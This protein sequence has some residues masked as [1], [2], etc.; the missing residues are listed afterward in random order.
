MQN[1]KQCHLISVI[2]QVIIGGE[3]RKSEGE[4]EGEGPSDPHVPSGTPPKAWAGP[5]EPQKFSMDLSELT[6]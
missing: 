3:E 2:V 4:E 5:E 6:F 1:W